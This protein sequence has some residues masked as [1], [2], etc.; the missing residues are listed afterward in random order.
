MRPSRALR[1]LA[2]AAGVAAP[3]A[4]AHAAAPPAQPILQV[5]AEMHSSVIRAAALSPQQD[6]LV[7]GSAD[8]TVRLWDL[9]ALRLRR[10]FRVP[11]GS[12]SEGRIHD[13]AVSP[14]GQWV[15]AGGW[16]GWE[17]D[18]S[19]SVYFFR[20]DTGALVARI[21][22]LPA[23]IGN[24][25]Y[26]RD[27]RFFAIGLMGRAGL[28][29]Y[30]ISPDGYRHV[31]TDTDYGE[32]I[33]SL[34]YAADGRL[35][36]SSP[37]GR[38]R[39]YGP[40][41]ALAQSAPTPAGAAPL[42]VRFSPDGRKL[43]VGYHDVA[44]VDV[45]DAATLALEFSP[46]IPATAGFAATYSV[47]WSEDGQLLFAGGRRD[48]PGVNPIVAWQD[49]G[50]G[51]ARLLPAAR[52][53][54]GRLLPL[55]DGRLAWASEDPALGVF[56]RAGALALIRQPPTVDYQALGDGL[57]LSADG[58]DVGFAFEDGARAHFGFA[59]LELRP[60]RGFGL[61]AP[62]QTGPAQ[63]SLE[64]RGHAARIAGVAVRLDPFEAVR[65]YAW[66]HDGARVA[67]ATEWAVRVFDARGAPL[68]SVSLPVVV[69]A[70]NISA[71]GAWVVAAVSD[72]TLRW[73]SLRDG[74][75]H[76][77]LFPHANRTEWVAW[78][79][80]GEY[81]ASPH[82]DEFVGWAL[83]QGAAREPLFFRA[84][85]FERTFYRPE[86]LER[87]FAP[88]IARAAPFA[89]DRLLALAPPEV[90]IDVG[91]QLQ[92]RLRGPAARIVVRARARSAAMTSVA[93]FVNQLPI[94]PAPQR[95][96]PAR[97]GRGLDRSF[98]VPLG[99]GANAIRIEVDSAVSRGVAEVV[100]ENSGASIADQPSD[101]Y[102]LAVGVNLLEYMPGESLSYAASD[103]TSMV[104]ALAAQQGKTFR[105]VHRRLLADGGT[106]PTKRAIED[107]LRFLEQARAV[108][109][110]IVYLA[111]HGVRGNGAERGYFF[112]PEDA[113]PEDLEALGAGS[114]S[115]PSL[116]SWR[117]VI[118]AME[119]AIGRRVL[120]LDTCHAQ[121][122]RGGLDLNWLA[123]QSAS[124]QFAML[125]ASSAEESSEED[126]T[127]GAGLYT[128]GLVDALEGHHDADGDGVV[129]LAEAHAHAAA[130]VEARRT[131]SQQPQFVAPDVLASLRLR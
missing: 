116:I 49:A 72:G 75:P 37:D 114:D 32:R 117:V 48:A 10:V 27:G 29:I 74:T 112:L 36:T 47:E 13:V 15:A 79:P 35:A 57:L 7:T 56:D 106:T 11:I 69:H 81:A 46:R 118:D 6:F 22:G 108:D 28:R 82:G 129:T 59:K 104:T 78:L 86:R 5:E 25:A 68:W 109:T 55:R 96:I 66:S 119:R 120:V 122:V 51:A 76:A 124:S 91:L 110:V 70:V 53:R 64:Q 60:G 88:P 43:A 90:A 92:P 3:A 127:L 14:D 24:L 103:A 65:H 41:H 97:E 94:T 113:R 31:F 20:V 126:Q 67:L 80:S 101:L 98:E 52:A 105:K 123:K 63:V 1:Q 83:N 2:L 95:A 17:W 39:V 8:K 4:I 9:A 58:S 44:R 131:G 23:A 125:A 89:A 73:F 100:V 115:A 26:S 93:V 50:H 84:V 54:I 71:D 45:L 128:H 34:D 21:S 38:I 87:A 85:Q 18:G 12:G 121:Q 111:G 62:Q 102:L 107:A 33:A 77:A 99:D 30:E 61:S 16:T 19:A 130:F 42:E 40:D